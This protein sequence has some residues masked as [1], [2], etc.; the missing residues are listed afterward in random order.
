VTTT[1]TSNAPLPA[2][3]Y[4]DPSGRHERRWWDGRAW[5][6]KVADGDVV[7][8]DAPVRSQPE[9]VTTAAVVEPAPAPPAEPEPEPEPEPEKKPEKEKLFVPLDLPGTGGHGGPPPDSED[10]DAAPTGKGKVPIA[11][12]ASTAPH[13]GRTLDVKSAGL[14]VG[15][16]AIVAACLWWGLTNRATAADWRDRGEALQEELQTV[17]SNADALEQAL[18]RSANRGSQLEDGRQTM[19]EIQEAAVAT[20]EQLQQ[21]VSDVNNALNAVA[22]GHDPTSEIDRANVSCPQASTNAG[23][24]RELLDAIAGQ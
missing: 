12:R 10:E 22:L 3:W 9:T 7:S 14:V 8:Q 6:D 4:R 11:E 18:A 2:A 15:V 19:V 21:C 5:T 13:A 1:D 17:S 23:L 16:L 24:L 20:T